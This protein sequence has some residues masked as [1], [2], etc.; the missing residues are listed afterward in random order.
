MKFNSYK[1]IKALFAFIMVIGLLSAF[2]LPAMAQNHQ[3]QS[4]LNG[5]NLQVTATS[6]NTYTGTNIYAKGYSY[7]NAPYA[8][9]N[10]L[11]GLVTSNYISVLVPNYVTNTA[12]VADVTLWANRDGTAPN[13]NISAQL[14]GINAA[15]TN[16]ATFKFAGIPVANLSP[17]YPP[18]LFTNA[19]INSQFSFS[20]TGNGTTPV[21]ITTNLPTAF[22]Q[23]NA[24]V[25]LL[26]VE[27]SN[28]GTNGAVTGL[29]LNGYKPN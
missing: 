4:F 9:T 21:V 12:G 5:F 2:T 29:F 23:G 27:W 1:I 13:A 14:V 24:G 16:T 22:L 11:N 17:S 6:T 8:Y 26:A 19:T 28:A 15:F 20:V 3:S 7:T 18:G 10:S 25:R